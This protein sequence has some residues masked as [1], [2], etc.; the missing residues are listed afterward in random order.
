MV[1]M[2]YTKLRLSVIKSFRFWA[3]SRRILDTQQF[4]QRS[5]AVCTRLDAPSPPCDP[6]D[7]HSSIIF[8]ILFLEQSTPEVHIYLTLRLS[9]TAPRRTSS[10]SPYERRQVLQLKTYYCRYSIVN[11]LTP[12]I[13]ISEQKM[14]R[15]PKA[16]VSSMGNHKATL[17]SSSTLTSNEESLKRWQHV[18]EF[19]LM[20]QLQLNESIV[21]YK[22]YL[23]EMRYQICS[24]VG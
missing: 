17:T 2:N 6:A 12:P 18:V 9:T 24:S 21:L 10:P 22:M 16:A 4:N 15:V 3:G 1:R 13:C 7:V 5:E 19:E 14:S 23:L 20:V 11:T 8:F